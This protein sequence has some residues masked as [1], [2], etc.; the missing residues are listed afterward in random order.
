M[1]MLVVDDSRTTR[2]LVQ[3][4]LVGEELT[5]C[6]AS[7]GREALRRVHTV[8][9]DI[10]LCDVFMPELGGWDFVRRLRSAM[11]S[12]V[13]DTAVILA[14][15]KRDPDME[16]KS[17]AAGAD[18]FLPKPLASDQLI[19]VVRRLLKRKDCAH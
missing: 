5:F 13:R 9:P 7:S 18:A 17:L 10:V 11:V 2:L 8:Q 16:Q 19:R 14:S 4:Y 1:C 3:A 12:R 15:S 6:E